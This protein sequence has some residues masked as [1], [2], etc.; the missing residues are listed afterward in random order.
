M[1]DGVM[2]M[3]TALVTEVRRPAFWINFGVKAVLICLLVFG[4]L[5]GLQQF[6][7]KAFLWRLV[8]YPVA[9]FVVP[10]TWFAVSGRGRYPY[11]AD[12]LLALPFLIDTVGNTL[13]LYDTIWWWD[14]ANHLVNWS[15]LS[16]AIGALAWRSQTGAWRTMA[17]VIG[18]GATTAILWEIA[19]YV[20]LIRNSAELDTAYVDTLGDLALGLTGSIVAG[21]VAALAPRKGNGGNPPTSRIWR[22]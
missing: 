10:I 5:S 19:E 20:A 4:A 7:G 6:E 22:H 13:D 17:Y 15:L 14:D 16:G 21:A 2:K 3:R 9:A 12:I 1:S 11:S 8:T 18:F